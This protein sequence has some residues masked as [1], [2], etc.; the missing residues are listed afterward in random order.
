MQIKTPR[1]LSGRGVFF[2]ACRAR[3]TSQ[4]PAL[5]LSSQRTSRVTSQM[6]SQVISQLTSQL[7]S[8][9][10]SP[11]SLQ[12]TSPQRPSSASS[13]PPFSRR[14]PAS[15]ALLE[16]LVSRQTSVPSPLPFSQTRRR[17]FGL[18]VS[19]LFSPAPSPRAWRSRRLPTRLPFLR[20]P[21]EP[22]GRPSWLASGRVPERRQPSPL[23][24]PLH[25]LPRR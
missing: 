8:L 2:P 19:S 6:T 7:T 5:K 16:P 10:F 21:G 18:P 15:R 13:S 12:Q 3:L 20:H 14:P 4:R 11:P 22:P 24:L 17:A 23:P 9:L 1:P 25:P